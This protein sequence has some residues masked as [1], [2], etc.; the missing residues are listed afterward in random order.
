MV[1][2]SVSGAASYC[3]QIRTLVNQNLELSVRSVLAADPHSPCLEI[4][5]LLLWTWALISHFFQ[6]IFEEAF[7]DLGSIIQ[8]IDS[9][10]SLCHCQS[11]HHAIKIL[12]QLGGDGGEHY[13]AKGRS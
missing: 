5:Q 4:V 1:N 11:D 10:S 2:L 12:T 6:I 13:W 7:G 9:P 8:N 3:G